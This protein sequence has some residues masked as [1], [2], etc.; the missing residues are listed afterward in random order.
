MEVNYKITYKDGKEISRVALSKTIAREPIPEI[1]TQGTYIKFG[2][3]HSGLGT[4]YAWKGGLY[5]A[6]PWLPMGSYVKVTN[7]ANGKS[8]IVEINDRGPL[9]KNRIIDLDKVAFEKI[10]SIGAGI[11]DIK[12]EEIEME[13]VIQRVYQGALR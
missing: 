13:D 5:A 6:S 2:K 7:R 3:T 10:A 12:V 4:W 1:I 11:I 8:V 9:G